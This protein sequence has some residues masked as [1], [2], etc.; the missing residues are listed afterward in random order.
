MYGEQDPCF[1]TMPDF[2]VAALTVDC[3]PA[4][5]YNVDMFFNEYELVSTAH[6]LTI[7]IVH[8]YMVRSKLSTL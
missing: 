3:P 1:L 2:A 7:R 6:Q 4:F 8:Q 5:M